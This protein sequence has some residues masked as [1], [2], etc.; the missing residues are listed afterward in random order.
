MALLGVKKQFLCILVLESGEKY[1]IIHIEE[2]YGN[3]GA[4]LIKRIFI[5]TKALKEGMILDQVIKDRMDRV[6]IARYTPLNEYLIESLKKLGISGVY[7]QQGEE[8]PEEEVVVEPRIMATI[9]RLKVEDPS[10][11]Q[12]SESVKKRVAE[13]MQYLYN[14]TSSDTFAETTNSIANDLMKAIKDNDALAVDISALK[15]SDEYTFKHSVDV[16]TMAMIVARKHGFTEEQVYQ[17]GIAGLLHD[18][19]KTKIPTEVLNKPGPLKE[20]EFALMRQHTLLGYSILKDKKDIPDSISLAVLQHHEKINGT[21]YPMG[22]SG[23][24]ISIYAKVL[25]VVDVYDALVTE[26]PYKT[27]FS[28]RDAMEMIMSLTDELDISIMKSFLESVILYPVNSTVQL[29]NGEKARVVENSPNYILRPK[30]V[31]LETGKVYDLGRDMSCANIII[32]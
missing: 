19:G 32:K 22:V 11:V 15:V 12:L 23:G 17:I 1:G 28:Q 29:S 13:G 21:G 4:A 27:A 7:I 10:K 3:G 5:R 25:A 26:R 30:V 18:V 31:G 6:L 16:A 14:N 9:E 2:I 20:E 24:Q 8:E